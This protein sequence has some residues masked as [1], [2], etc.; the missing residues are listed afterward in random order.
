MHPHTEHLVECS[1]TRGRRLYMRA[2]SD[3]FP[4]ASDGRT[5][6]MT[7]CSLSTHEA[8]Q[9]VA[10]ICPEALSPL[11]RNASYN[12][13][14]PRSTSFSP[15]RTLSESR[16]CLLITECAA[17]ASM[18]AFMI[19]LARSVGIGLRWRVAP[20]DRLD[21]LLK[22]PAR[23]DETGPEPSH[24]RRAISSPSHKPQRRVAS[25]RAI[26]C[27]CTELIS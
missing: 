12:C 16:A 21:H 15:L 11:A 9:S 10:E 24:P 20:L 5:L 3:R 1:R 14:G 22:L 27:P 13:A 6:R 23:R 8:N 25:G 17:K 2:A 19:P 18:M 26:F 7:T 4:L